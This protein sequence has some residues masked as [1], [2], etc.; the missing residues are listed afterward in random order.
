LKTLKGDQA[1]R[2]SIRVNDQVR[3]TFRWE[4]RNAYEVCVEDDH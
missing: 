1:G 4:H 2:H 3:V